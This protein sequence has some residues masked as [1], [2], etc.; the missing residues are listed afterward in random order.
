MSRPLI[1]LQPWA[2]L[3]AMLAVAI[4]LALVPLMTIAQDATPGV[5]PGQ[6]PNAPCA[7]GRLRVGDL[8]TIDSTKEGG[9]ER[10]TQKAT[11]WQP[12]ATLFAVR[13]VCPLLTSGVRWEGDY[14]SR[15]AQALY[16]TDT[17]E[18]EAVEADP[19]SMPVVDPATISLQDVYRTLVRAGFTDELSLTPAGGLTIRM[20]TDEHPFG[21][22]SAPRGQV[23]AH[24][25][26][27][28]S[29]QITDVWVALSDG[30]IYRYGR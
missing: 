29:G 11:T 6:D 19:E 9:L 30:T 22:E 14:F 2:A 28:V 15:T 18:V 27:E 17:G 7:N 12:D 26:I 4:T 24:V 5:L 13:V 16:A 25:A 23:Y 3:A 10:A 20:S 21:P 8:A 1:R